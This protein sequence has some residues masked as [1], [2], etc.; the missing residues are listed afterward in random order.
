VKFKCEHCRVDFDDI[1]TCAE[2]EKYCG[3]QPEIL[4][5]TIEDCFNKLQK[6]Y[7]L[8]VDWDEVTIIE[9]E[10]GHKHPVFSF[11]G[12]LPNGN[13]FEI[14]TRHIYMWQNT[15]AIYQQ[16][17][18]II[19]KLLPT[20][21]EGVIDN[22]DEYGGYGDNTYKIGGIALNDIADRLYGRK[23]RIEVIE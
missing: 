6:Q 19:K 7:N 1:E 4:A 16:M 13:R 9:E 11:E 3:Q 22:D 2:H 23:V 12:M 17:E 10:D 14:N 21:Y 8:T 15:E 18:E 20:S 5:K